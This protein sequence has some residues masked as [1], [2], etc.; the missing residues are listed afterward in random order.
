M[1]ELILAKC[2]MGLGMGAAKFRVD[3]QG[4]AGAHPR[5]VWAQGNS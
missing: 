1:P 5:A 2:V 4:S 3:V